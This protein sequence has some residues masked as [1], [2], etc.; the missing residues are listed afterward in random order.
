MNWVNAVI[1]GILLGGLYALFACGLSLMFGVM[2]VINLAHGDLAVVAAYLAL[3]VVA[4]THVPAVWSFLLVVPIFAV[5]GY[6]L[7][8]TLL[9]SA[10]NRSVLTTLLVTFG[11]SVVIENGLQQFLSANSHSLDIGGLVS[12]S[13]GIGSQITIAY[14]DLAILT[15]AVVVLLGLQYFLSS[16]KNG[17]LIRAVAD[18]REAA[19]LS[20]IDFRHVFGVAAAIAFGTVALAGLAFGMYTQFNPTIGTDQLLLFAFEAVVIGGLGSLWGTLAGGILL[21]VA[22]QV[23]AQYNA[24]DQV[25]AGQ[26]LFLLVLV[27][28]PQGITSRREPA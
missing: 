2:K 19:Q 24:A 12:D 1:Q 11:L 28:R 15:V 5:A 16:S 21:G 26:L 22:Q 9:Q 14:L 25:L 6:V 18:D 10:L 20:G 13:F 3:G 4:I 27:L 17:R 7:Q 8:R 23:G